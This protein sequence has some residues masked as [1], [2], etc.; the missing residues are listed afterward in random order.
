MAQDVRYPFGEADVQTLTDGA[1]IALAITDALTIASV[2][3]S[4]AATINVTPAADLPVGSVLYLKVTSDTTARDVTLGTGITG[5][6]LAGTISKTKMQ[7]FVYDGS[8]FI[9]AAALIQLD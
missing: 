9:A 3:L 7:Q 2:S 1:T 4:Q 5:P 6:T 8:A